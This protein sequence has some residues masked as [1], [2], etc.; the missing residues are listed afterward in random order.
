MDAVIVAFDWDET[1]FPSS[2]AAALGT[3]DATSKQVE[4]A[5]KKL[6]IT[7]HNAFSV[8]FTTIPNAIIS[9]VTTARARWIAASIQRFCPS[10]SQFMDRV[11]IISAR[12]LFE[13]RYSAERHGE[14]A[15]VVW[16]LMS[17]IHLV[18]S[19]KSE[20]VTFISVGDSNCERLAARELARAVEENRL[21]PNPLPNF[22]KKL[23]VK[24]IKTPDSPDI[25]QIAQNLELFTSATSWV[26]DQAGSFETTLS[27]LAKHV[28]PVTRT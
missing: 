11:Q 14:S 6:E 19:A 27:G 10:L 21:S 9:I 24:T 22:P 17:F 18:K 12:D 23:H 3:N 16:K 15:Y 2:W 26:I 5:V 25:Y 20:S 13:N 4:E 8:L 28:L 1:L 7:I